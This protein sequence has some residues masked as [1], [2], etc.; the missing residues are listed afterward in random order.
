MR[1]VD[2]VF[3]A[4]AQ[5]VRAH[6]HG[7]GNH[8]HLIPADTKRLP[9]GI[10]EQLLALLYYKHHHFRG[11]RHAAVYAHCII[12]VEM[13]VLAERSFLNVT[14]EI[15]QVADIVNLNFQSPPL[16]LDTFDGGLLVIVVIGEWRGA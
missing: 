12:E 1:N 14:I 9:L 10:G 11:C 13:V 6:Y 3:Q 15:V 8:G 4:D 7:H 2:I 16:F 5:A